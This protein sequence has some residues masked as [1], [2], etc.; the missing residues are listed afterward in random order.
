MNNLINVMYVT[1]QLLENLRENA[2]EVGELIKNHSDTLWLKKYASG[3]MFEEKKFT[4][5]DFKLHLSEDGNY[6]DPL[7][8]NKPRLILPKINKRKRII[9][10]LDDIND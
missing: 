6:E 9:N 4:I 3:Q 10:D 2:A 8:E 5:P 7:F 1:D